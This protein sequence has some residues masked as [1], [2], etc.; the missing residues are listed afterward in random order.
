MFD[1]NKQ[2]ERKVQELTR[3]EIGAG[4]KNP[5]AWTFTLDPA[6]PKT[7]GMPPA[8]TT[9]ADIPVMQMGYDGV[10]Q[11]WT[12]IIQT[13]LTQTSPN[14]FSE[15]YVQVDSTQ[16]ISNVTAT[17]LWP[18]DK[19]SRPTLLTNYSGGFV[20]ETA[21]AGLDA[22]VHCVSASAGDF[23]N[24]MDVDLYLACR[25]SASNIPNILY[26]NLGDGTFRQVAGAGGA[27][28]PVG[29]AVASGAGT[30]DT[31]VTGDY[32]V[33]GFLDLFVTNGFNLR[34]I[35][36]AAR[37]R[38]SVTKATRTAGSKSTSSAHAR[39]VMRW[40]PAFTR[41]PA[42]RHRCA[43]RTA[44]IIDGPRTCD[45][46]TSALAPQRQLICGWS[47]PVAPCSPYRVWPPIGCIASPKAVALLR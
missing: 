42:V 7:R 37:T 19:P 24:D 13:R 36:S 8:P 5:D 25:T 31:V 14:V 2:D 44:A 18:T 28:G 1:W 3:V 11:Q 29:I 34:P 12:V 39:I 21:R 26:E 40:V 4:A 9:Q 43:F 10:R 45:A 38:C 32:N 47:G 17:G 30:A 23:D 15:A 35:I 22:L 16:S 20:D 33:D 6:D 46:V 41:R 27:T